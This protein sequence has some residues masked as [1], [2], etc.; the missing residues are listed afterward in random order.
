MGLKPRRN[1]I[2]H[3]CRFVEC[4]FGAVAAI[5][6][7]AIFADSLKKIYV[8]ICLRRILSCAKPLL[9][10]PHRHSYRVLNMTIDDQAA[11]QRTIE[12]LSDIL[13]G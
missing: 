11:P 10:K 9:N 8:F 5:G 4:A 1:R 13:Q 3:A 6:D 2:E 12:L 7:K